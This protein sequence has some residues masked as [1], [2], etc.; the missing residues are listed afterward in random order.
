M[1]A[2]HRE[3]LH[4]FSDGAALFAAVISSV[5]GLI[6]AAAVKDVQERL[7]VPQRCHGPV[8]GVSKSVAL[9]KEHRD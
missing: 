9:L 2:S 4:A 3:E 8:A 5:I 7:R 6:W 1:T